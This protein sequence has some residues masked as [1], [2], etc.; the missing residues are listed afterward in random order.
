MHG[1]LIDADLVAARK[2]VLMEF[3]VG[4]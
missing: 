1:K 2:V 4:S 3:Q